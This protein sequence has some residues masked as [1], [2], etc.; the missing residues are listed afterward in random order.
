L[1][2]V[3]L[4]AGGLTNAAVAEQLF[5]SPHTVGTHLRHIFTKLDVNSRVELT[6]ASFQ[7]GALA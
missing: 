6:R 4:V 2:V 1:E 5:I 3:R 7:R